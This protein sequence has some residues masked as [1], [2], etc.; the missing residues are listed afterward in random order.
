MRAVS[1]LVLAVVAGC[2][3]DVVI[4]EKQN[5][6]P[7]VSISD[8]QDGSVFA[9]VD[10]IDFVGVVS[11]AA[12]LSDLV[13]LTWASDQVAEPLATLLD[14]PPDADG[15][16]QIARALPPGTHAISLTVVDRGGAQ[17]VASIAV[18]VEPQD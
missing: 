16:T 1:P 14:A 5:R 17:A 18:V 4:G 12:G 9:E 10:Q 15:Y 8:P 3:Q 6:P 7:V 11:D 13:T 2:S